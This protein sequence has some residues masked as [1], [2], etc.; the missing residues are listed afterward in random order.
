MKGDWVLSIGFASLLIVLVAT[1]MF[2]PVAA[3]T[4]YGK[5]SVLPKKI[6]LSLPTPSVVKAE[7]R[8]DYPNNETAT[9]DINASTLLLEG[10]LPPD[11]T[12][13][14]PGGL[15]AEFDGQMFVNIMWAHIYHIGDLAPPYKIWLDITGNLNSDAGGTPFSCEGDVVVIVHHSPPPP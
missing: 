8:L 1:T 6:D 2:L 15:M 12:Y 7:I 9:V 3:E 10:S 11:T 5:F 14:I 4:M 13:L